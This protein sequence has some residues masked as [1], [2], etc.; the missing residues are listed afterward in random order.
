MLPTPD[1]A[2]LMVAMKQQCTAHN[3]QPNEYFLMKTIQLYE[4]IVVRHG[5]M[6]V[7]Q[8]FSGKSCSLRVLAG[9]LTDLHAQGTHCSFLFLTADNCSLVGERVPNIDLGHAHLLLLWPAQAKK[10]HCLIA[11]KWSTSTPSL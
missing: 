8:P 7:G 9:A 2:A 11:S 6:T 4:M 1:Y 3:L 10:A 5:L